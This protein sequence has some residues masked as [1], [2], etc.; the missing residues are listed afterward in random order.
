[1]WVSKWM[2]CEG[3]ATAEACVLSPREFFKRGAALAVQSPTRSKISAKV[4]FRGGQQAPADPCGSRSSAQPGQFEGDRGSPVKIELRDDAHE[5]VRVV[6]DPLYQHHCHRYPRDCISIYSDDDDATVVN[7][8]YDVWDVCRDFE[9]TRADG[10]LHSMKIRPGRYVLEVKAIEYHQNGVDAT[11]KLR[12]T[13]Q[14]ITRAAPA[15][16]RKSLRTSTMATGL[17]I[18]TFELPL[19]SCGPSNL[20][21]L[22]LDRVK[23][24]L[25]KPEQ[26]HTEMAQAVSE[27]ESAGEARPPSKRQRTVA[28][29]LEEPRDVLRDVSQAG[30]FAKSR[31]HRSDGVA[32]DSIGTP[33]PNM[34]FNAPGRS[35]PMTGTPIRA[36]QSQGRDGRPTPGDRRHPPVRLA[37]REFR[38]YS[39]EEPDS[40]SDSSDIPNNSLDF[41]AFPRRIRN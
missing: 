41:M 16:A 31:Q 35:S 21:Q 7:N 36:V 22:D 25:W 2:V 23:N 27:P 4:F 29:S 39:S 40:G 32:G 28:S 18:Y 8:C 9:A 17:D 33:S 3:A 11:L 19:T 34:F 5:I 12:M 30:L 38:L 6:C 14:T 26:V 13:R 1:M 37:K 10:T 20:V 24:R 15:G